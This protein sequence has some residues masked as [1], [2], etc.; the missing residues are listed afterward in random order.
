MHLQYSTT[1]QEVGD[2]RG[3]TKKRV[4]NRNR[5]KM[6]CVYIWRQNVP[7]YATIVHFNTS[8]ERYLPIFISQIY[9]KRTEHRRKGCCRL[10]RTTILPLSRNYTDLEFVSWEWC[11][12]SQNR[13][14][15][16]FV[17][18]KHYLLLLLSSSYFSVQPTETHDPKN[19]NTGRT[20]TTQ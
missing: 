14:K 16:L 8:S 6:Y 9:G 2:R 17:P 10:L 13:P 1:K 15:P 19:I 3:N 5:R 11:S 7:K 4:F 20:Q 18:R 12:S